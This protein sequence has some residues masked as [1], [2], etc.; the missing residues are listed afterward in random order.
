MKTLKVLLVDD[1]AL[2]LKGLE[3]LLVSRGIEVCAATSDGRRAAELANQLN[4]NVI[5]LDIMMPEFDGIATL[6]SLR[7]AGIMIP[8]LMLTMSH[9][10]GH[11][12]QALRE[13]A[14]GYLLKDMDPDELVPALTDAVEGKNVV[15]KE[16]VGSLTRIIQGRQ[17]EQKKEELPAG[18]ISSLTPRETEILKHLAEGQSNKVIAKQLG[19]SDGTVK[20]H[21]KSILRKLNASS[22]VEAAVMAVQYNL[23]TRQ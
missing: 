7:S 17:P 8:V 13:G 10:E 22:R 23:S 5:L 14:Q 16:L 11:L 9:D 1:H 15:A 3:E 6:K 4:P 19:I 18:S 21:V 20:L 12:Q 2:V